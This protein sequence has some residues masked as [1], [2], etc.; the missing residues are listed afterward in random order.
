MEVETC[1]P[2]SPAYIALG[3][4]WKRGGD[5]IVEGPQCFDRH[6]EIRRHDRRLRRTAVP[7]LATQQ[8]NTLA[9]LVGCTELAKPK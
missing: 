8:S 6:V 2:L 5:G 4:E 9:G 1:D 3:G 7:I